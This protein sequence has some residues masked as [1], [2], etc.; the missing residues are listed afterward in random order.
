[1]LGSE[2]THGIRVYLA[3]GATLKW[4]W[5]VNV[6]TVKTTGAMDTEIQNTKIAEPTMP[7]KR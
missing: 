7:A 1:M 5:A 3:S 6:V 2:Q 4:V